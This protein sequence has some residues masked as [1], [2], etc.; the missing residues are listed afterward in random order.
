MPV[1]SVNLKDFLQLVGKELDRRFIE[2]K[3]PM[4]GVGW[5]GWTED[6]FEIEVFPNRPD[7]LSAEGLAR[8]F[9]AFI[10]IKPGL[11]EY[12]ALE[13]RYTVN[14]DPSVETVRP[15]VV[16]AV[17]KGVEMTDD[18]VRSLM[19]LQEKLHVTHCRRRRKASIG[20]YD[21]D[22]IRF[23][24]RYT[25][26]SGDYR[27][28]P[29][30]H[31]EEMTIEEILTKTARGREY[32]WILEGHDAYPI[33]VDSE[34]T[35]LSMP[36]IINSEETKVTTETES[37]FIEVTGV[38]WKTMN[39]VLNIVST[40]LA[41]R[42]CKVYQ[43]EIRYPDRSVKTP[44]L[45]CWEMELE[46][47]YVREL[48]GVDLRAE[49]VAELLGRMGYGVAEVGETLR[50]LVPC[51]RTD[52]MHPMDLVEDVAIAYGYDRFEPEIPNMA[53]IGEED[54]LER[55]SRN[56]RNLM[57][58]YGLQE[59]MTFILTNKRDLF[60]RMCVPEEPVAETENPK[61]EEYCVLRSWLLPSLMKV[62]E[63]NR[64]NPYPQNVFEVGDVVVLDDTTDTGAR[65]VKKLAFVLCHSKACFSE[66]KAI[67]ESLLTNLGIR[68]AT[69]RP[70]GPECFMDGR[71]SEV[72]VDN[73][74]LGFLGEIRPEVL[75]N[76]GLEMPAAAAELD[77]EVLFELTGFGQ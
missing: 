40:S 41:D 33:L 44:D 67:T 22:A 48:L 42:G 17:V 38:D 18:L 10:G 57:V 65:T 35:T 5:E 36:P 20:M 9:S 49:E 3:V 23:P 14:V 37:L 75:L 1:I 70:G 74:L 15:Y 29:L 31:S 63:R 51:Y 28:R 62:L 24:V 55:F 39:E 53:T 4:L 13:S 43:V 45:R 66:V 32:G 52:I 6:G 47:G 73:R 7:M 30:G 58:G 16:G 21:L 56:L 46:L 34:G 25:T 2:E 77:V 50:V 68:D 71:R 64:H 76:W 26:V 54:P 19:Q 11:R 69:F 59:V 8:A 61:T 12:R 60:E 27:F 72:C